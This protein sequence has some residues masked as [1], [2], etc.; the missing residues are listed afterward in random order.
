MYLEYSFNFDPSKYISWLR[1]YSEATFPNFFEIFCYNI[2][3]SPRPYLADIL[4]RVATTHDAVKVQIKY[5]K[6]EIFAPIIQDIP[7]DTT[8]SSSIDLKVTHVK[9]E[10]ITKRAANTVTLNECTWRSGGKQQQHNYLTEA[11]SE[12]AQS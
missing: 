10:A 7:A 1:I 11:I 9:R 4:Q 2:D 6:N 5:E 3:D 8:N 12:W